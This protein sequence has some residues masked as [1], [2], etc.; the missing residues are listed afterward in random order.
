ML[1]PNLYNA[2]VAG[3]YV[4]IIDAGYSQQYFNPGDVVFM[5]SI[6]RN[7]G[8]ANSE[9]I[10]LQLSS[11]SPYITVNNGS[12]SLGSVPS[13]GTAI[14]ATPFSFTVS[15]SAPVDVE[16][17]LL[18]TT[19]VNNAAINQ[20]TL[21][22]LLGTPVFVF[23]DTTNNPLNLWTVTATPSSSPKWEATTQSFYSAP[24]SYTDS[25]DGNYIAN[26]T[27]TMTTADPIDLTGLNNPKLSFWT[28]YDIESNYDYGQVK[29]STNNGT[30]WI[31]LEGQYTEPGVSP[32]QPIGEP[33]YD[34]V[35]S[36]WVRED[37]SLSG[38][39]S[40]QIKIQFQLR[41]DGSVHRDG[42]YVDDIAIYYL[43]IIPVELVSFTAELN[44]NKA[45]LK[46]VTASE[47]NNYGFEIE[48]SQKS[49][50]KGQNNWEKIG[51]V[52]GNGTT[53]EIS[54][55]TFTDQLNH[56][57]NHN[58]Y[59]R[60]KQIDLDG[61]FSYSDI[62]EIELIT[63]DKFTLKQNYPNPFNPSTTISYQLPSNSDVTLKVYD[64]LGNEVAVLV[65]E[66]KQ[67]G[68]YE[69]EFDG[70]DL[71]SGIYYYILIG[72]LFTQTKKMVLL[73]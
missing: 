14:I 39:I 37:I 73:K 54:A 23:A 57:F 32:F 6:F 13:R 65:N 48:K 38:Y 69:A 17:R 46:W 66:Y 5:N 67:S 10:D 19:L 53:T 55:Y 20:D 21:V 52:A 31:P 62:I 40:S 15:S 64:V 58:L 45:V 18:L 56:S 26:A 12:S 3:S 41:T 29:I 51:F 49:K 47:T 68:R 24:V 7:K 71:S 1:K 33:V 50:V 72:D 4:S 59:Y 27:V 34:G 25:K 44:N 2:W 60:L 70:A 30:T 9:N 36:N 11:L 28:R 35:Q 16:A 22:I 63:V 42:W 61:S 8:L 43:G